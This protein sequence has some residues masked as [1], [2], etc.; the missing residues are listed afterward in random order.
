MQQDSRAFIRTFYEDWPSK[1]PTTLIFDAEG[2]LEE[3]VIGTRSHFQFALML[4]R[5]WGEGS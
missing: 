3:T 4:E 5:I 1:F 2:E